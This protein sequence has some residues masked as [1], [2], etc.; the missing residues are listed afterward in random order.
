MYYS[1]DAPFTPPQ[2]TSST[3]HHIKN[4]LCPELLIFV[5]ANE[6]YE[7]ILAD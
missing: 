5:I 4:N 2:I 7:T 3:D 6:V 1:G